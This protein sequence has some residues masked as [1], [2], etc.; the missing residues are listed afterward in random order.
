M[1]SDHPKSD[2]DQV[3]AEAMGDVKPLKKNDVA[4]PYHRRRPPKPLPRE[5]GADEGEDLADLS[6]ETGDFLEFR[7][8]GVQNRLYRDLQRGILEPEGTLDLHGMRVIDARGAMVRFLNQSVAG[9]RRCVRII[10]GKGRSAQS[11]QPVLKHKTNQWLRQRD[12][13][14]AFCTAPRW[15][16]GTGAVYVLLRR[17]WQGP[18]RP[19]R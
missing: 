4:E 3:F 17:A 13:V 5:A 9:N 12:E 18:S 11:G 8:P 14:L 6:I 10:H 16:G 7:R 2:D 1:A 15:D 19:R